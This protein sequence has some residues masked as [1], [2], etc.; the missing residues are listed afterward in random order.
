[1]N[2]PTEE[3]ISGTQKRSECSV[4]VEKIGLL[5]RSFFSLYF[6]T[7]EVCSFAKR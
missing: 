4:V 6:L 3:D 5:L 1:M 7:F 2:L